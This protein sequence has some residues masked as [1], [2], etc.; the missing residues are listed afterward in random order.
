MLPGAVAAAGGAA[1]PVPPGVGNASHAVIME[2]VAD[3]DYFGMSA[4][5]PDTPAFGH[6]L[7]VFADWILCKTPNAEWIGRADTERNRYVHEFERNWITKDN[8]RA[9]T[10]LLRYASP[11]TVHRERPDNDNQYVLV[12]SHHV[13]DP[14]AFFAKING[15]CPLALNP[16]LERDARESNVRPSP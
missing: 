6:Y 9:V 8:R 1:F 15:E 2:N 13:S 10:L 16:T 4:T 3:H 14:A 12:I 7:K 5:Y 11:R